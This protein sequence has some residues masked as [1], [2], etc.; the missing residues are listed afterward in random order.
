MGRAWFSTV[1]HSDGD[2]VVTYTPELQMRTADN[3]FFFLQDKTSSAYTELKVKKKKI[4]R[5]K[6]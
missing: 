5:G 1:A 4:F 6:I 3:R 2:N